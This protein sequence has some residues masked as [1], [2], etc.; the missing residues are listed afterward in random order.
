M[1]KNSINK[2]VIGVVIVLILVIATYVIVALSTVFLDLRPLPC[3][4]LPSLEEVNRVLAE[5][6]E[7]QRIFEEKDIH[8]DIGI[9][10]VQADRCPGKAAIVI[11]YEGSDRTEVKRLIGDSFFGIPYHMINR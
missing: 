6:Q 7:I 9:S 5:H 1:R 10:S 8:A 11:F 4:N 2:V 3:K